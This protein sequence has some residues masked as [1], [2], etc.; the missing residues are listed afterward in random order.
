M[1]KHLLI[2]A[3]LLVAAASLRARQIDPSKAPPPP[4]PEAPAAQPANSGAA[5]PPSAPAAQPIDPST[6]PPPPSTDAP[7]A[8]ADPSE[9]VFDPLHAE[10]SME[11]GTYYLRTGK[12]DAAIDRFLEAAHYEPSLAKPWRALGEAYEKKGANSSAMEAYKKYLEIVPTAEDAK[13]IQ[14]RISVLEEKTGKESAKTAA[15]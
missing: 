1:L 12:I 14:K 3:V 7:D 6:P 15:H 4:P 5:T 10:R 8:F 11:V 13:K 9:P 2:C